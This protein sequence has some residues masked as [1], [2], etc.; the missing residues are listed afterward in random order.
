MTD[1]K[2]VETMFTV[3]MQGEP[4]MLLQG[5]RA[6]DD[7]ARA[8]LYRM[9]LLPEPGFRLLDIDCRDPLGE[10]LS[11]EITFEN[12]SIAFAPGIGDTAT[13]TFQLQAN[14]AFRGSTPLTGGWQAVNRPGRISC[15]GL[16]TRLPRSTDLGRIEVRQ[17]GR[18]LIATGLAD[19]RKTRIVLDADP[20]VPGRWTGSL[21]VR[22][23][24][25]TITLDYQVDVVNQ[26]R[27]VGVMR[28]DFSVGGRSCTL[29][30]DFVITRKGK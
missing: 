28:G 18:R 26:R 11:A 27:L 3:E 14:G 9:A 22:E 25:Q 13:C 8:D 5:D 15:A 4:V 10:R 17:G 12:Q 24:G 23:Q 1:R 20:N 30:R 19:G 7:E 16:E 29:T 6:T 2:D 21:K